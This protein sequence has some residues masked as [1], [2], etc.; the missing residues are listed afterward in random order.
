[1]KR[2]YFDHITVEAST[3][4]EAAFILPV[5]L[6]AIFAVLWLLF[7]MYAR[8]KLEADLNMAVMEVSESVAADGEEELEKLMDEAVS[9]HLRDYPYYGIQNTDIAA[10]HGEITATASVRSK[11]IYK[12][13][14][15]LFTG[16][17]NG[18]SSSAS[19]RYWNCP[20]IK[21]IISVVLQRSEP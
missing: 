20:G 11:V 8:I 21:R 3:T 12:G 19:V 17:M 2:H 14:Q 7:F 16:K 13:I 1:M 4:V 9:D 15:G 5:C 10:D 18:T 6:F